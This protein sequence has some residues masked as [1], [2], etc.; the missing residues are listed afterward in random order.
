MRFPHRL[1]R[2]PDILTLTKANARSTVHRPAY[3][4]YIGVK[5]F[6]SDGRVVGERRFLGLYTTAAYKASPHDIPLLRGSVERVLKRAGFD[7]NRVSRDQVKY[8]PLTVVA[9]VAAALR[10]R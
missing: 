5:K 3:L 10:Q 4:D 7:P 2:S 9:H 1:A 8:E 6:D